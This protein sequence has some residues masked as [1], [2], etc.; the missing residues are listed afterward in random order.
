MCLSETKLLWV[1]I[2]F[3][4]ILTY[5]YSFMERLWSNVSF[6]LLALFISLCI[7]G[8]VAAYNG[9]VDVLVAAMLLAA[10]YGFHFTFITQ[11]PE[12]ERSI[13]ARYCEVLRTSHDAREKVRKKRVCVCLSQFQPIYIR[14]NCFRDNHFWVPSSLKLP[15]VSGVRCCHTSRCWWSILID[16]C[17][18]WEGISA[19]TSASHTVLFM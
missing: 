18:T 16:L 7:T 19:P 15:K 10:P 17:A 8:G 6:W 2:S 12:K 5:V 13:R 9:C 1:N 14:E 3:L 11:T 4:H